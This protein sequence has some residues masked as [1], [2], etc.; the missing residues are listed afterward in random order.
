MAF[1]K[2]RGEPWAN[3]PADYLQW[4][5]GV[6]WDDIDVRHTVKTLLDRR[7]SPNNVPF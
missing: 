7:L 6:E 3:V 5:S 4:A 2:Y 1:G